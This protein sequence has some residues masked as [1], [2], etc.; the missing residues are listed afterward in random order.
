MKKLLTE[1]EFI[2]GEITAISAA[3]REQRISEAPP[4]NTV[5]IDE[6]IRNSGAIT[7]ADVL[8]MVPGLDIMEI[9]ASDLVIN[10]RGYNKETLN[11]CLFKSMDPM[12]I[13][14]FMVSS[15]GIRFQLIWKILKESKLLEVRVLLYMKQM[16]LVV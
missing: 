5:N 12:S 7:I 8:R 9:S 10:A 14:I 13:G 2:F 15:C 4:A 11:K 3:K 6:G 1:E 16:H